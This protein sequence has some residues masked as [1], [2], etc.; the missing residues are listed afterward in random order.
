MSGRYDVGDDPIADNLADKGLDGYDPQQVY[1]ALD[2]MF[3]EQDGSEPVDGSVHQVGYQQE[4]T[5][6]GSV[7]EFDDEFETVMDTYDRLDRYDDSGREPVRGYDIANVFVAAE[8]YEEAR[9]ALEL[10]DD[11]TQMIVPQLHG[12]ASVFVGDTQLSSD[13]YEQA[14]RFYSLRELLHRR[15]AYQAGEKDLFEE[16]GSGRDM[17]IEFF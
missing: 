15:Q 4:S 12:G 6:D 17:D 10:F 13:E 1:T 8:Q 11:W 14:V 7:A 3:D 5:A 16:Q 2:T 9:D